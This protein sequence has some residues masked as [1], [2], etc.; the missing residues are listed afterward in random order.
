M[1][2]QNQRWVTV[3]IHV[4]CSSIEA[5]QGAE[6]TSGKSNFHGGSRGRGGAALTPRT[7]RPRAPHS[8][9][10]T[11]PAILTQIST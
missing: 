4:A 7:Q 11:A 8:L 9:T 2:V 3:T 10:S 6:E 1:D 5:K